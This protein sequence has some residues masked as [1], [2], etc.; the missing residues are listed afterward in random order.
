MKHPVYTLE[1]IYV[2]WCIV[3]A[4]VTE[5]E[6]GMCL[7]YDD[8]IYNVITDI[9]CIIFR[10]FYNQQIYVIIYFNLIYNFKLTRLRPSFS[11]GHTC[12]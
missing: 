10:I 1:T 9:F 8:L 12:A 11:R 6:M 2:M 5:T 7:K 4:K 3:K